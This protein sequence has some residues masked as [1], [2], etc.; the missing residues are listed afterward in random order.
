M[1]RY[2]YLGIAAWI[3]IV[4]SVC[5]V[6]LMGVALVSPSVVKDKQDIAEFAVL[7]GAV[8]IGLAVC[9]RGLWKIF[10]V[11]VFF[12]YVWCIRGGMRV[13]NSRFERG[14]GGPWFGSESWQM[15]LFL[16]LFVAVCFALKRSAPHSPPL[17]VRE[18]RM[19]RNPAGAQGVRREGVENN[20]AGE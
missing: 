14:D 4:L 11:P 17:E 8:S 12:Y 5:F 3:V 18:I 9:A 16:G 10:A 20:E 13:E 15:L 2:R 6:A 1:N 19:L 7:A